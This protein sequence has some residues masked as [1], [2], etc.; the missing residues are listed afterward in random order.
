MAQDLEPAI[1]KITEQIG[2]LTLVADRDGQV[3]GVPHPETIGQ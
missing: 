3:M 1:E 2:K